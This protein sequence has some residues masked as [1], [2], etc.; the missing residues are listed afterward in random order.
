MQTKRA[1]NKGLERGIVVHKKL[2]TCADLAEITQSKLV[3]NPA[4]LISSVA[5]LPSADIEDASFLSNPRYESAM[6]RSKAGAIFVASP[7]L[8]IEGRNFLIN[9]SPSKAFQIVLE[10]FYSDSQKLTGF[11]GIHPSAVIHE[12][13]TIGKGVEIGPHAVIDQDV[14]IGDNTFIGSGAYIGAGV[15]IGSHCLIHPHVTIRELCRIGNRVILHP[16]V[17]IGSCGFGFT[18]DAE[19]KHHKLHQVGIVIIEDDVDIGANTTIDRSRFKATVIARGTKIDNLVQIGHGV[20]IGE[21]N[22]IVSQVGIAGS[23]IT[24]NNVVFGGQVGVAGHLTIHSG[25]AFAAKAGVS[26]SITEAGNYGGVPA[27]PIEEYQRKTVL[28]RNIDKHLKRI[29]EL[30]ARLDSLEHQR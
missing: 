25:V 10:A 30:E 15:A 24:G 14:T 8:I 3:G 1:Q 5:D 18:T 12:S 9:E 17:V 19:G 21:D 28:M 11:H 20:Q 27:V 22:I 2:L 13:A 29:R 7:E 23:T 16:G 4:H 6:K 26:K